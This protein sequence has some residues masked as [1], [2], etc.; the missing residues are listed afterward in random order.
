M[1]RTNNELFNPESLR[2]PVAHGSFLA[3]GD[4]LSRNPAGLQVDPDLHGQGLGK[5]LVELTLRSLLG[6]GI[7]GVSLFAD[8]GVID[9]YRP[10]GFRSDPE[11]IKAMFWYPR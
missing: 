3:G 7:E 11:G 1:T 10:M 5:S 2:F 9:F 6:A 8:P 4:S